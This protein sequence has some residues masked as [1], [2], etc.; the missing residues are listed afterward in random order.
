MAHYICTGGCGG[1]SEEPGT[2]QATDCDNWG[3]ELEECTCKDGS[4]Q[5][6]EGEE[7]PSKTDEE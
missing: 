1:S 4:H 6:G 3:E 5:M 7:T 2:C